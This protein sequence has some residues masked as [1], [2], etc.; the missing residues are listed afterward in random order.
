MPEERKELALERLN[1]GKCSKMELQ[2]FALE[3]TNSFERTM[4]W[5]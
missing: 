2:P 3:I 1:L 5:P 4:F